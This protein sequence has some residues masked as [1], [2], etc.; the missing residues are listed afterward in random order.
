MTDTA[1]LSTIKSVLVALDDACSDHET[2]ELAAHLAA[3]FHAELQGLYIED[4][5]LLRMAALPFTQEI[6]TA[7]GLAREIDAQ[8]M[9]RAMQNKA[10]HARQIMERTAASAQIQWSFSIAR[11]RRT[12]RALLATSQADLVLF[13]SRSH[14]PAVRPP[15]GAR[16]RSAARPLV[17]IVDTSSVNLR[18]LETAAVVGERQ[19]RGIIVLI[20][21]PDRR[22]DEPSIGRLRTY[23][24]GSR[25][26]IPSTVLLTDDFDGLVRAANARRAALVLMSRDCPFLDEVAMRSLIEN[27]DCS[28]VLV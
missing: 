8:S 18:L 2:M 19:G 25:L 10:E 17:V 9:E 14:A 5:D 21:D 20:W 13:G 6:T 28:M 4:T 16:M 1:N 3:D 22:V 26:D 24:S 12:P 11:G 7:S 23:F 27:L 15:M